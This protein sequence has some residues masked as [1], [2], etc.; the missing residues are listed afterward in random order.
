MN[1]LYLNNSKDRFYSFLVILIFC[2]LGFAFSI[3]LLLVSYFK[4]DS[5]SQSRFTFPKPILAELSFSFDRYKSMAEGNMIRDKIINSI[6]IQEKDVIDSNTIPIDD[7]SIEE[8]LLTGVIGGHTSFAL[9]SFKEKDKE[10]SEE[11]GIFKKI[12]ETGYRVKEISQH[13]AII[14]KDNFVMQIE[15]GETIKE[16]KSK[17]INKKT[18]P[19]KDGSERIVRKISR[20][21]F[22]RYI[23]NSE[24]LYSSK[25]G[26]NLVDGK[27]D[28]YKIYS[29]P[30]GNL[31][32]ELGA[33]NGDL[34][35]RIN[36]VPLNNMEKMLEIWTNIKNS[37]DIFIDLD[38]KNKIYTY[39]FIITN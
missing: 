36:G 35:K 39:H 2:S 8:T 7:P 20:T 19:E 16:A 27:I 6:T 22:Y 10:D 38:R 5:F 15:V 28:G 26:P 12:G 13:H 37:T 1:V 9:A 23:N 14:S 21:D 32:Y 29:I 3:R 17:L 4:I 33:R 24:N 34:I 11:Y 31:F 30:K 18:I 25:L